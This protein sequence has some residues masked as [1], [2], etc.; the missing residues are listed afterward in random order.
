MM[1]EMLPTRQLAQLNIEIEQAEAEASQLKAQRMALAMERA[2]VARR[3]RYLRFASWFRSPATSFELWPATVLVSGAGFTGVVAFVLTHAVYDS[4]PAA[5]LGCIV[6]IVFA[7]G[8]IATL[9]CLPP[10]ARLDASIEEADAKYR[11]EDARLNEKTQRLAE[12][13]CRLERLIGERRQ[14]VASD[15][16][17]RAVLLQR[18]WKAMRSDEWEDY[19]VEVFR[20]LGAKAERIGKCGDQGCD[21]VVEIG[22]KRI[23]VQAKGYYHAVGN[24]A[25]QE[26]VAGV[27]HYRCSAAAVITNSRFTRG[28]RELAESNRCTLIGEDE[29]PDFVMGKIHL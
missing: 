13:S 7:A 15:K 11:L 24:K 10:D 17:K 4:F 26:A 20:T 3:L 1:I 22:P 19:L 9:L 18:N 5:L 27:A 2:P 28:A 12:V 23:A 21:L 6:G 8:I 14:L 16:L 25:V 29:F